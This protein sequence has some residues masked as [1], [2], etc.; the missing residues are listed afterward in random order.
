NFVQRPVQK[1]RDGVVALDGIAALRINLC[2]QLYANCRRVFLV[3]LKIENMKP[4]ISTLLCIDDSDS[5][6]R[7]YTINSRATC[8]AEFII[9]DDKP[10]GIT[11][12]TAHFRSEEHT[13]E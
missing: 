2:S 13:S 9:L 12:L 8:V 4:G 6:A 11:N 1:M 5:I 10:S 7:N 3:I